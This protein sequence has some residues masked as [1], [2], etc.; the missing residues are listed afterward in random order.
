MKNK[1]SIKTYTKLSTMKIQMIV[2]FYLIGVMLSFNSLYALNG[3]ANPSVIVKHTDKI[4][5]GL[6]KFELNEL[7]GGENAED[8]HLVL[9]GQ[10]YD[11][12]NQVVSNAE[13]VL[14][15][16]ADG[17]KD[18]SKTDLAGTF[19]FKLKQDKRYQLSLVGSTGMIV[20]TKPI[21]TI[22][23][24]DAE[25]LRAVLFDTHI[26]TE[27]EY[28]RDRGMIKGPE[29]TTA[30]F[31]LTFKIQF[32]AFKGYR[33][34]DHPFLKGVEGKIET[35]KMSGDFLRYLTGN[36]SY[37]EEAESKLNEL[38]AK[39]YK[40]AFIVSY[41]EEERLDKVPVAVDALKRYGDELQQERYM[42]E[43]E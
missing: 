10:V 18:F 28:D 7:L 8:F 9:V 24:D 22:N 27:P 43:R 40:T 31:A 4:I 6:H 29:T 13:V 3:I 19:Y 42:E 23:K 41:L 34:K 38:K 17:T 1:P 33:S 21:S 2:V 25:I 36:Y 32:G 12:N 39:G 26:S 14:I 11:G 5:K 16:D 20:D 15:N 35:E 30:T 37:L